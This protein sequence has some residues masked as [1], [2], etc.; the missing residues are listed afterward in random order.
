MVDEK[1]SKR[2]RETRN[3]LVEQIDKSRKRQIRN[4]G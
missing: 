4:L 1:K 3:D 2:K